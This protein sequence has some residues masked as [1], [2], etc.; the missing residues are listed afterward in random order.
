MLYKTALA[1][2]EQTGLLEDRGDEKQAFR[3]FTD[4]W[5]HFRHLGDQ[6]RGLQELTYA[7]MEH[8]QEMAAQEQLPLQ[9]AHRNR[10]GHYLTTP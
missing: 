6:R 3:E 8:L 1:G 4:I 7:I 10:R 2:A 9:T 5:R